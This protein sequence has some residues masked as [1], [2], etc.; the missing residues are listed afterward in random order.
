M[1]RPDTAMTTPY[2]LVIF[3]SDG[4][5]ANSF[6][7]FQEV[8]NDVAD[9]FRFSRLD[10]ATLELLRSAGPREALQQ[11][12]VP[13][14]KLPLIA[15]HMRRLK[16]RD[17]DRTALFP[18]VPAMLRR[19]KRE[20]LTLAV[21]SSDAEA[22]VR[23]TLGP[24]N[25][26]LIDVYACGVAVFG[27]PGR[28]RRLLRHGGFSPGEAIAI[29]DEIR[30]IEAAHAAGIACGAVSWGYARPAALAAH[31]PAVLFATMEEIAAYV[32]GG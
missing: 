7:W 15:R 32:V 10:P 20:G 22:N 18:G 29:G 9:R 6:P 26:G 2:R 13:G 23:R 12:G 17:A 5:L 25:A 24:L 19:L 8:I 27:K 31:A 4:T 16:A 21:L 11:L 14:W 28:M 30:D 1:N 3:D